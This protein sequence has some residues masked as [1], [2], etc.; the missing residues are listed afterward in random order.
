MA[1]DRVKNVGISKFFVNATPGILQS[2]CFDGKMKV[3]ERRLP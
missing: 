1:I 2:A 3:E